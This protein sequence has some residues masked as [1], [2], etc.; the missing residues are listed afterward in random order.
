MDWNEY[1]YFY[2]IEDLAHGILFIGFISSVSD[3]SDTIPPARLLGK[4]LIWYILWLITTPVLKYIL[5]I[6]TEST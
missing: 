3:I 1:V 4:Y 2:F 5:L 6:V